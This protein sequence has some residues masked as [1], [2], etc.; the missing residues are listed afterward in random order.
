MDKTHREK[1][2]LVKATSLDDLAERLDF[3][4]LLNGIL[5]RFWLIVLFSVLTAL[6]FGYFSHRLASRFV[7][8]T[9]LLFEEDTRKSA[10]ETFPLTQ[11]TKAS[12][13]D[14]VTLPT[15][16]N[17]VRAILGLELTERQL[18]KMISVEPP[19]PDSNLIVVSVTADSPSLAVDIA[20]TLASVV[21][22][23][24][25][26]YAKRQLNNA[27][28]YYKNQSDSLH[29][30]L[31]EKVKEISEFQKQHSTFEF[32]SSGLVAVKALS[33]LEQRHQSAIEAY[34]SHLIQ[35]ENLRREAARIPDQIVKYSEVDNPLKQQLAQA[36]LTLLATRTRYAPE[37]PKVKSLE[38]EISQLKK[39]LQE[40]SQQ[41][42]NNS[43][44]PNA[45]YT[46]NPVKEQLN[47]ELL[48]LRGKLRSAQ[49][50]REDIEDELA[51]RSKEMVNLPDEQVA[52]SRLLTT[53]AQQEAEIAR[54]ESL[55]KTVEALMSLGKSGLELYQ[56][57][58]KAQPN[59]SILIELL[60][61]LGFVLGA[62][63]GFFVALAVELSDHRLR[64]AR[65]VDAHYTVPCLTT[66]P[67]FRFFSRSVGER[68][69]QYFIR[70]IEEHIEQFTTDKAQFSIAVLSSVKG[71]GKS[72][73]AYFL[74]RYYQDLKK[75]CL[76]I[77]FDGPSP[78]AAVKDKSVVKPLEDYLQG[79]S[80][81]NAIILRGTIDRIQ[82]SNDPHM[83]ELLKNNRMRQLLDELKTQ[84]D[85]ILMD[86]P[87]IIEADYA[88]NIAMFADVSLFVIGSN[89]TPKDTVELS[90][91]DL[92]LHQV[93]PIGIVLNRSLRVY[94]DDVRIQ[95]EAKR[96]RV[97]IFTRL[98]IWFGK[99]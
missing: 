77:E 81:M 38:E 12:A 59:E 31:A 33:D 83:K 71:E 79:R 30:K 98:G 3:R 61:L 1:V 67:E 90:L 86:V 29:D 15:N 96:A 62:G 14:M 48:D 57:A 37:N 80:D 20:N 46:K 92:E 65:E 55:L 17:A 34:N 82:G 72:T 94:I 93:Q 41:Q 45:E 13:V 32:G 9:Y 11:I 63:L 47:L 19:S 85:V 68:Q 23:N 4:R 52:F 49:K 22:K 76:L 5:R 25:K 54:A 36:E 28:E 39:L 78:G 74:G 8:N 95:K 91:K 99:K 26:D 53:R 66:I 70:A 88:A 73:L 97:G 21:V 24:T 51:K 84:Y 44:N 87:G 40:P 58:D 18:A 89:R 2:A 7:A 50:L 56:T 69:L 35:Y 43:S 10:T 16:L 64:T 6:V 42:A 75:R 60:P 27:Y